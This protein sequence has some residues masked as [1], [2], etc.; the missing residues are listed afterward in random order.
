MTV[1]ARVNSKCAISLSRV[2][3]GGEEMT[4]VEASWLMKE[5]RAFTPSALRKPM[6]GV[7]PLAVLRDRPLT[8]PPVKVFVM[9]LAVFLGWGGCGFSLGVGV[10]RGVPGM[11]G[12]VWGGGHPVPAWM[13][14]GLGVAPA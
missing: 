14:L 1:V 12:V 3:A 10:G 9:V 2:T 4:L 8:P 7:R 13:F 11:A 6:L 5:S